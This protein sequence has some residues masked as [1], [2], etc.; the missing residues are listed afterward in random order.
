IHGQIITATSPSANYSFA[1]ATSNNFLHIQKPLQSFEN[2]DV[3]PWDSISSLD[4]THSQ[5]GI[6]TGYKDGLVSGKE[7]GKQV[8]LMLGFEIGA[9][10]GYFQGCLDVWNSDLKIKLNCYSSR[11]QQNIKQMNELIK[12]YPVFDPENVS[13]QDI[14]N[15]LRL[16]YSHFSY[17][18]YEIVAWKEP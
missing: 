16:N 7:E 4:D 13:V 9:E 2:V 6:N 5:E 10:L 18:V 8:G 15:A 3:D 1:A 14:M 17:I 11:I 12:T